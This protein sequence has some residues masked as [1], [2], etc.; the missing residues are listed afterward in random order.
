MYC[1]YLLYYNWLVFCKFK[2]N[3]DYR[4][5]QNICFFMALSSSRHNYSRVLN[6]T[7]AYTS[8]NHLIFVLHA[9]NGIIR[10]FSFRSIFFQPWLRAIWSEHL[11]ECHCFISLFCFSVA[12]S[13]LFPLHWS[14]YREGNYFLVRKTQWRLSKELFHFNLARSFLEL[15]LLFLAL[16]LR[17]GWT[18]Y[19]IFEYTT[20]CY[21]EA[22]LTPCIS[23]MKY[24]GTETFFL[25]W[26]QEYVLECLTY[27]FETPCILRSISHIFS[28]ITRSS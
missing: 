23:K 8:S 9:I 24:F 11:V 16:Y 26:Y 7:V 6:S 27:N 17:T 22:H 13:F 10:G 20:Q 4:T 5:F 12:F 28:Y 25:F 14:S 2:V 21:Q 3:V 19:N 18:I 15:F 1:L